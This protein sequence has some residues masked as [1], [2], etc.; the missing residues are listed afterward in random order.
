MSWRLS[1]N[2]VKYFEIDYPDI[3]NWKMEQLKDEKMLTPLIPIGCDL[4]SDDW[5]NSL[6]EKGF[7]STFLFS[8]S[9]FN[10]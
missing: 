8:F 6:I 2:G 1:L 4:T 9:I 5:P 3:L 10:F 7:D